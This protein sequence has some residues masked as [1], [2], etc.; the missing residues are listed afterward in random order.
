MI[1]LHVTNFSCLACDTVCRYVLI[2]ING[3]CSA[4]YSRYIGGADLVGLNDIPNTTI[5]FQCY[6]YVHCGCGHHVLQQS[7]IIGKIGKPN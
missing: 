3:G 4:P 7:F 5:N 6:G 2:W 1:D